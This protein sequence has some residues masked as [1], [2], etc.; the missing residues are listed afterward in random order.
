MTGTTFNT[1]AS[2]ATTSIPNSPP[3]SAR[4]EISVLSNTT[5]AATIAQRRSWRV[6]ISKDLPGGGGRT[7]LETLP[8]RDGFSTTGGGPGSST[9]GGGPG[10]STTDGGPGSSTTGGGPGSGPC[11]LTATGAGAGVTA[12]PHPGTDTTVAS[13][14][15]LQKTRRHP[16][17]SDPRIGTTRRSDETGN[18]LASA[19][20]LPS[21]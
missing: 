2:V 19:N 13:N 11:P 8:G 6:T 7:G 9:T 16:H 14:R 4:S 21:I 5:P 12:S 10:S 18:A 1:E 3:A 17:I 20:S 15:T